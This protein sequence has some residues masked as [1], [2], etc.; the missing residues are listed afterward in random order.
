M[1]TNILYSLIGFHS[2]EVVPQIKQILEEMNKMSISLA[3]LV[4]KERSVKE[5]L[6][7]KDW[8][9]YFKLAYLSRQ[10]LQSMIGRNTKITFDPKTHSK[11]EKLDAE[12]LSK[13]IAKTCVMGWTG[14]TFEWLAKVMNLDLSA[15]ENVKDTLEFNQENLQELLTNT[16]GI[17]GWIFDT[18]KD[19]AN[20]S[21]KKD[22]EAKN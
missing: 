12:A 20:F 16:Y 13:E 22:E 14:V 15:I 9:V 19:A 3:S 6:Y 7:D 4:K 10:E 8:N 17:E 11:E 2:G 5:V 1:F 21:E 18:V